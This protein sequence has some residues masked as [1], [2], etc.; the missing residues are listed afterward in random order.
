METFS[1]FRFKNKLYMC[2]YKEEEG[3]AKSS[4]NRIH[5]IN[6]SNTIQG[7]VIAKSCF[8]GERTLISRYMKHVA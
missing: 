7:K 4:H 6:N 3:P 2:E 1:I 8:F 5:T